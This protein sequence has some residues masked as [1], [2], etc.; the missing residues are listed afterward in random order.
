M[1]VQTS[2]EPPYLP[3]ITQSQHYNMRNTFVRQLVHREYVRR[4]KI[5]KVG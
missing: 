3:R 4:F 5:W 1:V 2:V